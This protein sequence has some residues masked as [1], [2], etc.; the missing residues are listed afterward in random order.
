MNTVQCPTMAAAS[1]LSETMTLDDDSGAHEGS[2]DDNGDDGYGI[3]SH[4]EQAAVARQVQLLLDLDRL[5]QIIARNRSNFADRCLSASSA[6][7]GTGTPAPG[8]SAAV[9][10]TETPT[11]P[12][13]DGPENGSESPSKRIKIDIGGSP[14]MKKL[15]LENDDKTKIVQ[16]RLPKRQPA[17]S[18]ILE[19]GWSFY[20]EMKQKLKRAA[21]KMFQGA[22][23]RSFERWAEL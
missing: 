5:G 22:L 6:G 21:M 23:T 15:E 13:K 17:A 14:F 11:T 7:R 3:D 2:D 12:E 1:G 8:K 18:T 9:P 4:G 16:Y 20:L 19:I 10:S